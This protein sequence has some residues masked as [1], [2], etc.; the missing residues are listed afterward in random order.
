MNNPLYDQS[1][2][3]LLKIP[4]SR[5]DAINKLLL[6]PETEAINNFLE[7]VAKYCTPDEINFKAKAARQ[8]PALLDRVRAVHPEYLDDLARWKTRK[9]T[10][11]FCIDF[12]VPSKY[13]RHQNR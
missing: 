11:S 3:D 13:S 1:L 10:V 6:D 12:R 7:I 2:R 4:G 8:L 5:L 9:I